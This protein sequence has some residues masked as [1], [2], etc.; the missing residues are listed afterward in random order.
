MTT[1]K[2]ACR[3]VGSVHGPAA[4]V[5]AVLLSACGSSTPTAPTPR[6]P[7]VAGSYTGT[8]TFT[9]PQLGQSLVCPA[10]TTINQTGSAIAIAPV[11]LS[12]PCGTIS[13]PLGD[14][15]IDANGSIGSESGTLNEPSCGVYS[16]TA[17]GGFFG[18]EFQF[19]MV[20]S[21]STCPN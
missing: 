5:C 12:G 19:A 20:A 15:D 10:T 2:I 1:T 3:P 9:Y 8:V 17:S 18:R 13:I 7:Q 6:V 21:S 4:L 14:A 16:Y 11:R